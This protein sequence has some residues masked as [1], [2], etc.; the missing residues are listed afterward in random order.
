M[1]CFRVF[2]RCFS[3]SLFFLQIIDA[4]QD[5]K[6]SFNEFVVLLEGKQELMDTLRVAE[7][8]EGQRAIEYFQ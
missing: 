3:H 6:I 2:F 7:S 1:V 8:D 4:N 5:N